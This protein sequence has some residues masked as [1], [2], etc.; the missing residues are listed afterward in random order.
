MCLLAFEVNQSALLFYLGI[1]SP[2]CDSK[3]LPGCG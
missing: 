2:V 1:S 3:M